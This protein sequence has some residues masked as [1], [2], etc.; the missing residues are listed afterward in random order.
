VNAFRLFLHVMAAS[1]WVG[2]QLVLAALVPTVRGFGDD[3]ARQ[4]A[5]AFNRIA[6]PAF[7]IAVV[8]GLWNVFAI[9]LEDLQ[10]PWIELKVLAVLLSGVGAA[11]HQN[12]KGNPTM[13]A[14]GGAVSAVFAVAS[15]YLGF[16]VTPVP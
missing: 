13:L 15:M 5:R 2:G 11:V 16:L 8:T 4:V 7:A 6:W 1:V 9:P 12:A 10:H 3:A 14:A